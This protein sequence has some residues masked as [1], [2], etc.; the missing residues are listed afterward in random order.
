MKIKTSIFF[1]TLL[2]S[3]LGLAGTYEQEIISIYSKQKNFEKK[4]VR[5]EKFSEY[6]LGRSYVFFPIGEGNAG[7]F[8]Q[9]PLYRTDVFDCF[10][11]VTLILALTESHDLGEFQANYVKINYADSNVVFAKRYHFTNDWNI[12]NN[13]NGY[14]TDITNK[15]SDRD[16]KPVAKTSVTLIDKPGWFKSLPPTR[17]RWREPLTSQQLAGLTAKLHELSS[18]VRSEE[19]V[20]SYI[21]L[22]ILFVNDKPNYYLFDQIPS[23]TVV[24]IIRSNWDLTAKIGTRLDVSHVGLAIRTNKGLMFREAS[25]IAGKVIDVPLAEYLQNCLENK[26]ISGINLQKIN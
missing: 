26:T 12:A 6:F 11:Y 9:N 1:L 20:I 18:K 5:V 23:G 19:S 14:L 25:E 22:E 8:D 2:F 13:K 3:N 24:E 15:I 7:D 16:G 21:P 10:S 4:S 17:I